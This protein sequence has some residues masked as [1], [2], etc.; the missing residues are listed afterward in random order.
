MANSAIKD[1]NLRLIYSKGHEPWLHDQITA[2]KRRIWRYTVILASGSAWM[3]GIT[4]YISASIFGAPD[5]VI[6]E[7]G[8]TL[9][10]VIRDGLVPAGAMECGSSASG[11]GRAGQSFSWM[12]GEVLG[13]LMTILVLFWMMLSVAEGIRSLF[14]VRGYRNEIRDHRAFLEKYDRVDSPAAG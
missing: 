11:Y 9:E 6:L 2:T 5:R 12:I 8:A 13:G 1:E 10:G 3:I 14:K 4:L 7:G